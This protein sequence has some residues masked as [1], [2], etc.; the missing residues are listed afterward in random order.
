MWF[1][2]L[3]IVIDAA[4]LGKAAIALAAPR[5]FYDERVRVHQV[6]RWERHRQRMLRVVT[7]PKVWYVDCVCWQWARCFWRW[8]W[9]S[10]TEPSAGHAQCHYHIPVV[11]S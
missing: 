1:Q 11:G 6:F 5:R 2:V 3:S 4:L 9:W 10:S 8:A 7:N